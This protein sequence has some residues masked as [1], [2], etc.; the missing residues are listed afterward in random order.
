MKIIICSSIDFTD[1]IKE[2][3]DELVALGHEVHIP[4]T[5]SRII[6]GEFTL[7]EFR[8]E[9][10]AYGDGSFRKVQDDV[11][12]KYFKLIGEHDVVLIINEEK[13]GMK[14]YIG[15]NTFL[16]MGF[17]HVLGKKIY[18]YNDIPKMPYYDELIAMSSEVIN[19][20]LSKLIE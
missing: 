14:G 9:K 7:E 17:A 12:K 4:F 3:M 1:R 8:A 10:E 15:G 6:G 19:G 16:E 2:V 11:I 18:L 20:D 13:K 5:S